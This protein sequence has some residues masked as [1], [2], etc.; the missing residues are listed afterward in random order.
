LTIQDDGWPAVNRYLRDNGY[1]RT[2]GIG[3]HIQGSQLFDYWHDPE[4]LMMEHFADGDLFDSSMAAGWAEMTATGLSQWGP[5]ISR[6]FL[7]ATP[8]LTML[9]DI[10]ATLR[11]DNEIDVGRLLGLLRMGGQ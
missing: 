2:W 5:P 6:E 11:G 7:G 4:R 1:H 8:S 9:R 10:V 3:R